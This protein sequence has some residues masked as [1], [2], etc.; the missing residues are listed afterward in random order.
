[1]RTPVHAIVF[2]GTASPCP[3]ATRKRAWFERSCSLPRG[4]VGATRWVAHRG[5]V[6]GG[7]GVALCGTIVRNGGRA[8]NR[9]GMDAA[10]RGAR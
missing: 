7:S 3:Y 8:I 4:N 2:R 6:H 10:R 1:M 5:A 9:D